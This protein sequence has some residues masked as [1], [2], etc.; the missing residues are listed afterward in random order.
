MNENLLFNNENFKKIK[1]CAYSW[2]EIFDNHNLI[3]DAIC[4]LLLDETNIYY[5]ASQKESSRT[6]EETREYIQKLINNN[7]LNDN[8]IDVFSSIGWNKDKIDI[9]NTTFQGDFAEYLMCIVIDKLNKFQ[10][11]ISK[12][13]LKT[14]PNMPAYGNDN[15]FFDYDNNILYYGE[16]KFYTS[17][18][19]G[20]NASIDSLKKHSN[21][22][23][24]RFIRSHTNNFIASDETT[25]RKLVE[26]FEIVN[27]EEENI[28]IMQISF[29]VN[30]DIYKKEDYEKILLNKYKTEDNIFFNLSEI[31]LIFLPIISK[32]ELLNRFLERIEK[33]G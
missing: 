31:V 33:Y 25:R 9:N 28:K 15:I 21:I 16:S 24:I 18:K 13:S 12:V 20:F 29:I 4:D 32:D 1:I 17:A 23:E 10:T 26:K 11:L 8:I 19:E 22:T 30:E 27:P 2:D 3:Y 7:V 14:S 5:Y 6:L